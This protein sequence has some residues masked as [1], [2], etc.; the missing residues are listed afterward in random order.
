MTDVKFSKDINSIHDMTACIRNSR[1]CPG[2]ILYIVNIIERLVTKIE[3][4]QAQLLG[5]TFK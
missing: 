2:F 1:S 5:K 4:R 3:R